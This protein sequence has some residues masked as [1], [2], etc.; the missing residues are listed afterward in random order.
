MRIQRLRMQRQWRLVFLL[1]GVEA[2]TLIMDGH[3]DTCHLAYDL[4]H[5]GFIN[6]RILQRICQVVGDN[7][8]YAIH[9]DFNQH[10]SRY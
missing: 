2:G 1:L 3:T 10:F 7:L 6:L 4:D 9:I 8:G 5:N